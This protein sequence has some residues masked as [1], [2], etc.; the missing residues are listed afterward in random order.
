[1]SKLAFLY[2]GQGVQTPGMGADFYR[3]SASA[4]AVFEEASEA[5]GMDM[6]SLCFEKNDRLDKTEYTQ[7]AL[8]T[9]YLAQTRVL[10]EQG[11]MPDITAGLSL[12]EYAALAV[13]H[14]MQEQD[15]IRLVRRRGILMQNAVPD[16]SGAMCAV[17]GL[18]EAAVEEVLADRKNVFIANYNCPGQLVITGERS[19]VEEAAEALRG[20]GAR[21]TV[22]LNVGGPFHSPLL[23]NAA[24]ELERELSQTPISDPDI[25]Y[26]TN[27][28]AEEVMTKE[29]I[30]ALLAQQICAPVRWMQSM[31]RMLADGVD[32]FVEIGAGK[33]LAGC[34][35]KLNRNVTVYPATTW[36]EAQDVITKLGDAREKLWRSA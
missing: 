11:I 1:M 7:A 9:L 21:R 26:I 24:R 5:L 36:E 4:R 35:R 3:N 23:V 10:T 27:V 29:S 2:P 17:L 31:Q 14:A 30:R 8:V 32:T 13:S 34:L 25:P 22:M 19:A 12:G 20:A 15:A 33:T 6:C 28:T 16:G 18:K